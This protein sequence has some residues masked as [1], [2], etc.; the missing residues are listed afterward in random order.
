MWQKSI[1]IWTFVSFLTHFLQLVMAFD[2]LWLWG[3]AFKRQN[4][5]KKLSKVR[6]LINFC[7]FFNVQCF[8]NVSLAKKKCVKNVS[9]SV[10]CHI[11][12]TFYIRMFPQNVSF[13]QQK[14]D[15]NVSKAIVLLDFCH[16]F[17]MSFVRF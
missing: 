4:C 6:F 9:K 13:F 1:K 10:F 17:E 16:I 14:Y 3:M 8:T 12:D 5:D 15:K 11:F 2:G 7:H